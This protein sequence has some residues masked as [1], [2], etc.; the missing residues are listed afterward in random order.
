[1][2]KSEDIEQGLP[3]YI[4]PPLS[5][6]ELLARQ[7]ALRATHTASLQSV[8]AMV[9]E[10]Q[11]VSAH[12]NDGIAQLKRK[13]RDLGA[14]EVSDNT[15]LLARITRLITRRDDVLARRSISD[16]LVQT[17]ERSV[18]DL[19]RASEVT[20]NLQR[21]AAE[22]QTTLSAPIINLGAHISWKPIPA[23]EI[24]A[25][26]SN[27]LDQKREPGDYDRLEAPLGRTVSVGVR[28][29]FDQPKQPPEDKNDAS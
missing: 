3:D 8:E 14:L 7:D 4:S 15:G 26:F 18:V 9:R 2:S 21:T 13:G 28:M 25:N 22:L 23:L 20:D 12:L 24:H 5:Q 27:L 29:Q 11:E 17:H 19:R 1:M 6:S 10:Q 16:A